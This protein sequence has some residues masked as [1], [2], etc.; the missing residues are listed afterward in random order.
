MAARSDR[1]HGR[2]DPTVLWAFAALMFWGVMGWLGAVMFSATPR[3]AAFDLDLLVQAGR[4]VAAGEQPYDGAILRGIPPD[5]FG[6]FYSYPPVVG[7]A[8]SPIA[9]LPLGLLA[10]LTSV[11]AV[12]A[13]AAVTVRLRDRLPAV[14]MPA[15]LVVAAT[16]AV[17]G[18]TLP[19]IV[20]VLFGNLDAF[21]PALY[22]LVLVA[23]IAPR[24]RDQ[25]AGGVA[26]ALGA[27]TKV[28]PAALGLW[29]VARF[30]RERANP[31]ANRWLVPIGA[32]LVVVL[33]VVGV[34][35]AVFG[36]GPWQDYATVAATA[37]RAEIVDHRNDAPAAQLALW[38]GADSA[39]ARLFHVP[40]V[41]VAI[42]AIVVAAWR[43]R[44]P[45]ESLAI[46]SVASLYVLPV[47]WVHY[48]AVLIP[49]GVAAVI[50][51]A[52]ARTRTRVIALLGAALVVG[53]ISILWLPI[54]WVAIG[55]ALLAI[56]RSTPTSGRAGLRSLA[57]E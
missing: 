23:A 55:L 34:S 56:H 11:L 20:A 39:T 42:L 52:D 21:F 13:T 10:I 8:L 38:L 26:L 47:S 7:Q 14:T 40:V 45:L 37:A 5:A 57:A 53:A 16:V 29:F 28:Y 46:A 27:V 43:V 1:P 36:I 4:A 6:L 41:V 31:D 32:A 49:F 12:A 33:V 54:L 30:A 17:T 19:M 24:T 18:M 15:R 9:G 3:I 44:D 35:I 2:P 25:A 51:V 48:P 22:G 50:R